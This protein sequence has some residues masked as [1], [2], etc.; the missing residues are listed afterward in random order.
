VLYSWLRRR[1]DG[2]ADLGAATEGHVLR[3]RRTLTA[4]GRGHPTDGLDLP[5]E[6]GRGL[7]SAELAQKRALP[8]ATQPAPGRRFRH[9]SRTTCQHLERIAEPTVGAASDW[10]TRVWHRLPPGSPARGPHAT[11]PTC[12]IARRTGTFRCSGSSTPR[13]ASS[14]PGLQLRTGGRKPSSSTAAWTHFGPSLLSFGARTALRTRSFGL[15]CEAF[16]SEPRATSLRSACLVRRG[17]RSWI[18]GYKKY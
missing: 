15:L 6:E 3:L 14:M 11:P 16:S 5:P 13:R 7:A 18:Q 1:H 2:A 17:W 9:G 10:L 4:A 8:R 12:G